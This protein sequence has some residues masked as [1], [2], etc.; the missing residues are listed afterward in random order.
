MRVE[1]SISYEIND[2]HLSESPLRGH[3]PY[4]TAA[5]LLIE[6]GRPPQEGVM[7]VWKGYLIWSPSF[8]HDLVSRP[9]LNYHLAFCVA[10]WVRQTVDIT[11]STPTVDRECVVRW[12]R[13]HQDVRRQG[14]HATAENGCPTSIV[15]LLP[16]R[17]PDRHIHSPWR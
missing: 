5:T 8:A 9:R 2:C 10:S 7:A 14:S 4:R 16:R 17:K 6:P 1:V 12:I 3:L 15:Q 13:G 11:S